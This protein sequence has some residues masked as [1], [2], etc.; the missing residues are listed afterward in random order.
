MENALKF[1]NK[2]ITDFDVI[3]PFN[4]SQENLVFE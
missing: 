3:F 1:Y 2:A 4:V